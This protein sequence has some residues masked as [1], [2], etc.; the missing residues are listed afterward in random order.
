MTNQELMMIIMEE[1]WFAVFIWNTSFIFWPIISAIKRTKMLI[2]PFFFC[3]P[4]LPFKLLDQNFLTIHFSSIEVRIQKVSS[5]WTWFISYFHFQGARSFINQETHRIIEI[6]RFLGQN[7]LFS[8][9]IY[10]RFGAARVA[11]SLL[12]P[13]HFSLFF[14][15]QVG[16]SDVVSVF[17]GNVR[18]PKLP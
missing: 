15:I 14:S 13:D 9:I 4:S 3:N 16:R 2:L 11:E 18:S 10:Y 5:S 7:I 17:P 1:S 12:K 6:S 8:L